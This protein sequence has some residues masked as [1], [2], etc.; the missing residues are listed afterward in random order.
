[1]AAARLLAKGVL[2]GGTIS[3]VAEEPRQGESSLLFHFRR[4]LHCDVFAGGAHVE[5]ELPVPG[6]TTG[7]F[8]VRETNL[9]PVM[10]RG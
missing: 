8:Y 10:Q 2:G 9:V 6:V 7:A 5:V 4:H 1:M 3:T